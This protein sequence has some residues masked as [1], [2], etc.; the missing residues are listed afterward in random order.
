MLDFNSHFHL[1]M[2]WDWLFEFLKGMVKPVAALTVVLLAVLLSFMQNLGLEK[3]MIY[4]I[5][6]A[7]LQLS[8]IGFVLQFI[9]NQDNSGWIVLAYLFMVSVAGYTA[10]QRA[11]H[12]PRGKYV[13]GVS[14]LAGTT[15]TM[16]VLVVLNVF[17]F[18]PRYIIPVAGMMVGNAMTVTGVTMKRLRDDIKLQMSLVETA[19]ALGATPRQATLEQVKRALVISLSPVLD[20]AKT[21]GLISLPGAM[22]GLI[23]GGASPLEAIQL[24]IVVMNMLIGASTVSSIMSTYLCWPAFFT[25]AYQLE[26]K[27]FSSD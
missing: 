3:E 6:R 12:V 23:M 19:L 2:D 20:N 18:T 14:I 21:V 25:K 15:L 26:T 9:F 4:S 11:K 17:P 13:A 5:F 7:F 10:G 1:S 16:F 8:I 24:Q 22:T 27:V